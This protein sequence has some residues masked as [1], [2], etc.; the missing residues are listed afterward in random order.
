MG[1][2]SA[3]AVR[4]CIECGNRHPLA[5]CYIVHPPDTRRAF[6]VCRWCW[7]RMVEAVPAS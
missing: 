4:P 5:D 6:Y 3:R 2:N 7:V 1:D